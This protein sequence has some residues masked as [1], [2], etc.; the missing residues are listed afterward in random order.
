LTGN[1]GENL[2][3]LLS[4]P[5]AGSTLLSL[6]LGSHP[7]IHV[8]PEPWL[9]ILLADLLSSGRLGEYPFNDHFATMAAADF[10]DEVDGVID[11]AG[12]VLGALSRLLLCNEINKYEIAAFAHSIYGRLLSANGKRIIVDKTPRY[13]RVIDFIDSMYPQ[14]KKIV[15]NRN[16]LDIALSY[17]T[18]WGILPSEIAGKDAT[19][20]Q[21]IDFVKG[22]FDLQVLISR[23]TANTIVVAYEELVANPEGILRQICNFLSVE[24]SPSMLAYRENGKL[25]SKFA[26]S[27]VGD[28]NVHLTSSA[29]HTKYSGRW[30]EQ[31]TSDEISSLLGVLG[32]DIFTELGYKDT[33]QRIASQ[34]ISLPSEAAAEQRR[35]SALN[36]CKSEVS[37]GTLLSRCTYLL[38]H[39]GATSAVVT[40]AMRSL[41]NHF[42][43]A[44]QNSEVFS[45]AIKDLCDRCVHSDRESKSRLDLIHDLEGKLQCVQ[46][47]SKSRLDLIHGLEGKLQCVQSDSEARLDLIHE[48]EGKL[49][50]VQSDSEARLDLIHELEGK[51]QCVQS[52]SKSRLDLI[53]GLEGKLQC[54][55]SDSKSRLDLIHDLEGKLQCVQSDSEARLDLIHGL[56]GKL[57]Q[58]I[59][60]LK[61]SSDRINT[62]ESRR[63]YRFLKKIGFFTLR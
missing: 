20:A 25:L 10:L 46:S 47:D 53:H 52:D 15:L 60:Q 16:P 39:A 40:M 50:C 51:L 2:V 23:K 56:E 36:R 30:I 17:K 29:S 4:M 7:E 58:V 43:I 62:I 1:N 13:Y 18:T 41:C 44:T 5:R 63:I 11:D 28:S 61:A 55:Q 38:M 32:T 57:L 6:M 33:L 14:A 35:A 45:D 19:T 9:Q 42:G 22:L 27:R 26:K 37:Y 12:F 34:G 48:L 21:T 24:F 8:P 31:F 59:R 54:V 49:Q 3:F